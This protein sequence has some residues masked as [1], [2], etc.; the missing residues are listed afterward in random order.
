[1]FAPGGSVV[2]GWSIGDPVDCRQNDECEDFI[3]AAVA[4]LDRRDPGHPAIVDV[5]LHQQGKPGQPILQT[6]SGGC[7]VVAVFHLLDG[8]VRAIGVGTPGVSREPM[9]F[10]YGPGDERSPRNN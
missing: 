8:S 4:G 7:A 2:D 5:R 6:C 10:D 3:P 1:M 9:T